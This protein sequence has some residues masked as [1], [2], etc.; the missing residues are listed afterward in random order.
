MLAKT[1]N[2]EA[3]YESRILLNFTLCPGGTVLGQENEFS[4]EKN[5][6]IDIFYFIRKHT[7]EEDR[8]QE[9]E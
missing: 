8:Q 3:C 7:V 6:F 2:I 1:I 4:D 5:G 9:K